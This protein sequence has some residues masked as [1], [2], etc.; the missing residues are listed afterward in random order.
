[1]EAEARLHA[2]RVHDRRGAR[3]AR[4]APGGRRAV[5]AAPA[6]VRGHRRALAPTARRPSPPRRGR[7]P[8][9]TPP[10]PDLSPLL[11]GKSTGAGSSASASGSS[12]IPATRPRPRGGAR[13]GGVAADELRAPP[14][15]LA[16]SASRRSARSSIAPTPTGARPA[17]HP[18]ST[19]WSPP[20]RRWPSAARRPAPAA[21]ALS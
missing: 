19:T 5:R 12:P 6:A 9:H 21:A 16:G 7:L 2:A 14:A 1:M 10:H 8:G 20:G 18:R 3:R 11:D 13:G 17:A 4:L 15:H